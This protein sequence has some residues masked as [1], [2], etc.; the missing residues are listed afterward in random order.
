MRD[1]PLLGS[2]VITSGN[3]ESSAFTSAVMNVRTAFGNAVDFIVFGDT[4]LTGTAHVEVSWLEAPGAGDWRTL[5]VG[6]SVVTIPVNGAVVVPAAAFRSLRIVSSGAE[7][8]DRTFLVVVQ[9]DLN[10]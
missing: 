1:S 8:A 7:A 6:G 5:Y 3:T 4:A 10:T 2:L 9:H